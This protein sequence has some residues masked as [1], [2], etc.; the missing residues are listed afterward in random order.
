MALSSNIILESY[1][2]LVLK[3]AAQ[4]NETDKQLLGLVNNIAA[5]NNIALHLQ[6]AGITNPLINLIKGSQTAN[7]NDLP[8]TAGLIYTLITELMEAQTNINRGK[9]LAQGRFDLTPLHTRSLRD[10]MQDHDM[11]LSMPQSTGTI[12]V[13]AVLNR[14]DPS[15]AIAIEDFLASDIFNE[16]VNHIIIPVGPGHWRGVFLTKQYDELGDVSYDLEL[17]DP[18][19]PTGATSIED[20][21]LNILTNCGLPRESINIRY[22][23]PAHPQ[24]DAYSC[25]DFTNAYCHKKM[26][27]YGALKGSYNEHLINTLE[28][29]GNVDDA[30]RLMTREETRKIK[31]HVIDRSVNAV[32]VASNGDTKQ[33]KQ[34]TIP[35]ADTKISPPKVTS[36]KHSKNPLSSENKT[37]PG[38]QITV[39]L[40]SVTGGTLLGALIGG[41]VGFFGLPVIG[42]PLGA[43]IG[44]GIGALIGLTVIG[45]T[46]LFGGAS[47]GSNTAQIKTSTA[48]ETDGY[49]NTY[50][51]APDY[52]QEQDKEPIISPPLFSKVASK[53]PSEN[54]NK[55]EALDLISKGP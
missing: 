33:S 51:P 3:Y 12:S 35:V 32:P 44:A 13:L 1:N 46:R 4:L 45:L 39:E 27:E 28:N 16:H 21:T 9:H 50:D 8:G 47:A 2:S 53:V 43:A 5:E 41:L 48:E 11:T 49:S 52:N 15:S 18:Y 6:A 30:L 55:V 29:L 34:I 24:G 42:A 7:N 31:D 20:Y 10:Q 23:G 22:T 40:G 54:Q 19:G 14:F 26:K 36:F 25:G 37:E 38:S 17:F